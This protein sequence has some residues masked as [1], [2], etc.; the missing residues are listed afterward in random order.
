MKTLFK[1]L[2]LPFLAVFVLLSGAFLSGRTVFVAFGAATTEPA[3]EATRTFSDV[4]EDYWAFAVIKQ[5]VE[6]KMLAGYPDGTFRPEST[7]T[8]AE[9]A[10]LLTRVAGLAA[11]PLDKPTHHDVELS[12]W[13]APAV[14]A[15]YAYI[16]DFPGPEGGRLFKPAEPI[17][18]EQAL[19]ALLKARQ[20]DQKSPVNPGILAAKFQDHGEIAPELKNMLGWAVEQG[21]AAGYPEGTFRPRGTLTRAEAATLLARM[22]PRIEISL[23]AF[24]KSGKLNPLDKTAPEYAKL[25]EKLQQ[26]CG[27]VAVSQTPVKLQY[28]AGDLS[29]GQGGRENLLY[30]FGAVDPFKYFTF[31]DVDF[32]NKPEAVLE[33]NAAVMREV[34]NIFPE[35]EV[36]VLIGYVNTLYYD[37]SGVYEDRFVKYNEAEHVWRIV[38]YYTGVRGKGG[39]LL[40]KWVGE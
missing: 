14:G 27:A 9:F 33:F 36:I 38:R 1:G 23:A 5:L 4:P 6:R 22:F 39:K 31:S 10:A 12:A 15:S 35:K 8:R 19:A 24:L 26:D 28:S 40:E 30:V 13:Y 29:P 3:R 34:S 32:K 18:R 11:A 20:D 7:L 37:P 25:V 17:S 2:I 21:L 16:G